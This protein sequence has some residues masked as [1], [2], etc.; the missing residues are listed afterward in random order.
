M[1]PFLCIPYVH[2]NSFQ[3]LLIIKMLNC[4][5]AT[6]HTDRTN[7]IFSCSVTLLRSIHLLQFSLMA[8]NIRFLLLLVI[9]ERFWVMCVCGTEN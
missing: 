5:T 8:L 9:Q 2:M 6:L 3:Y 1:F 4:L 7:V